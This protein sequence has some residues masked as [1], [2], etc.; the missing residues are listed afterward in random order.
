MTR[1]FAWAMSGHRFIPSQPF[2]TDVAAARDDYRDV[3]VPT[4]IVRSMMACLLAITAIMGSPTPAATAL[5]APAD[6]Y[7][8]SAGASMDYLSSDDINRE[9]DAVSHT[10][11]TWLRILID[12]NRIEP[13]EGRYDWSHLDAVVNAARRHHLNLLGVIAYSAPWARPPG[14]FFT[15]FPIKPAE[16]AS[17][18]NVVVTRYGDRIAHWQLWNE[19]NLPLFSGFT[20]LNGARYAELLKTAYPVIKALQP[21]GAVIAAGLSRK[22][23]D[24]SPPAFLEQMYDSGARGFFDAVAAHPYVFPGGVGADPENGWSD[25]ARLHDVMVAHGDERMKIWLTEFG[26]PT[27]DPASGGVT[28]QEQVQQIND[29]LSAAAATGYVGPAFIYSI[30]DLDTSNTSDQE[31]NFGALLTSDFQP[32][33]AAA[34][35]A[36]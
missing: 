5:I 19:P 14:S 32:K 36:R 30:R 17:F 33:A 27:S 1:R 10:G 25:V 29:I 4:L 22:I 12:W 7:G 11:A 16:F 34:M 2:V 35:L 13:S 26:A 8:F 20:T 31:K 21:G 18:C 9:L 6:G 23:G 15:A 3:R 24:D 28:Q